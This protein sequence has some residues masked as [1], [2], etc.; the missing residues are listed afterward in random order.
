MERQTDT[1]TEIHTDGHTVS[2]KKHTIDSWLK[3]SINYD[4]R[5]KIRC[6][7]I[8]FK[9]QKKLTVWQFDSKR[10]T[11]ILDFFLKTFI[12][13]FDYWAPGNAKKQSWVS[14]KCT[15]E[16]TDGWTDRRSTDGHT[17]RHT[18]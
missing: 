7:V 12:V 11:E 3:I 4:S 15:Y 9:T 8:W 13:T 5:K 17:D 10:K 2:L 14:N 1:E 16:E 18:G 6:G